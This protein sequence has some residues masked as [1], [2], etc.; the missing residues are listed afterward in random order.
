MARN[1][2]ISKDDSKKREYFSYENSRQ[3]LEVELKNAYKQIE[4]L[5]DKGL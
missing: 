3:H 5:R 4:E 2:I 1:T